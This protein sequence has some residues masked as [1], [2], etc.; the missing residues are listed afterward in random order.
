MLYYRAIPKQSACT[1]RML[2]SVD[3][4]LEA[5]V[6]IRHL[7]QS[8]NQH[9]VSVSMSVS[10]I[11]GL[12]YKTAHWHRDSDGELHRGTLR[13]WAH[14]CNAKFS[15]YV[16]DDLVACPWIVVICTNP[17]S[18]P[19]PLPI[20]T[21]PP[22][23]ALLKSLLLDLGWRLADA[24]PRKIVLDSA[25]MACFR[26]HLGWNGIR[27]PVLSDLHPSLGNLDHVRRIINGLR[28]DYF[29][30]G[31]GFS[32]MFIHSPNDYTT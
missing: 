5:L 2:N 18:H 19:P 27:D 4:V 28:K 22:I 25:F 3:M 11:K 10:I 20:S 9:V 14:Q 8:R 12:V 16:P 1:K 7:Q 17:H 29:V 30:D 31:T 21:P 32:G 24:T 15:I 6:R 13:R 23:L 26:E